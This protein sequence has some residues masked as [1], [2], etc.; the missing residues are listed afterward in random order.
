MS[1]IEANLGHCAQARQVVAETIER[2]GRLDT[3]I[4]NAGACPTHPIEELPNA[5]LKFAKDDI[6]VNGAKPGYIMTPAYITGQ[7]FVVDGSSAQLESQV[8]QEQFDSTA[9]KHRGLLDSGGK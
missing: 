1:L 4:P 9:E 3:L 6:S 7:T 2:H 8:L 5:A